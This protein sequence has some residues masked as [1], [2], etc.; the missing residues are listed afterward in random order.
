MAPDNGVRY[1]IRIV[2]EDGI[3]E[4]SEWMNST[5]QVAQTMLAVRRPE[6][7]TYWLLVRNI[8]C[9]NCSDRVQIMEYPIMCIPSPRYIPYNSPYRRVVESRNLS[10]LDFSASGHGM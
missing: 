5:E 8:L 6:G 1:R 10:A 2:R 7:K 3:E 9:P 4:L